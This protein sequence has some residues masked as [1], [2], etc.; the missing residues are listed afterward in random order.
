M[1]ITARANTGPVDERGALGHARS[2]DLIN[3]TVHP[4]LTATGAGFGHLEVP[5]VEIIDDKP[6]LIFSCRLLDATLDAYE[7][8]G[9]RH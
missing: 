9:R 2:T 7:P 4:P 5:Q 1:L 8:R 3:W 6:V